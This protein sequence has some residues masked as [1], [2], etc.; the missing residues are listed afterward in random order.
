MVPRPEGRV[1]PGGLPDAGQSPGEARD[2]VRFAAQ[3]ALAIYLSPIFLIV[4]LIGGTSMLFG[5][6]AQAMRHGGQGPAGRAVAGPRLA[7]RGPGKVAGRVA[8]LDRAP[9][10]TH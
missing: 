6:M 4:C 7:G 3:L 9:D 2:P 10:V 5:G 8:G 1:S